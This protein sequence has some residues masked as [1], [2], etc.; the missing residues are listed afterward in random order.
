VLDD[1]NSLQ[2]ALLAPGLRAITLEAA[3]GRTA[4]VLDSFVGHF[5]RA[6]EYVLYTVIR[7][8]SVLVLAM[9]TGP[10]ALAVDLRFML[11]TFLLVDRGYGPFRAFRQRARLT[12][13]R[14]W[15]IVGADV[16]AAL[17]S[18]HRYGALE[19]DRCEGTRRAL[20]E[21]LLYDHLVKLDEAGETA[22]APAR[23]VVLSEPN[24]TW[25]LPAAAPVVATAIAQAAPLRESRDPDA[26]ACPRCGGDVTELTEPRMIRCT[27]CHGVWV[28]VNTSVRVARGDF[29]LHP[30]TSDAA[31]AASRVDLASKLRCPVCGNPMVRTYVAGAG[32]HLD[33]CAAHG[34]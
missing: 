15:N 2:W 3:R 12:R 28:D 22:N 6:P 33:A 1:T 10:F 26:P 32:V 30:A 34:T 29:P 24:P 31:A 27:A 13:G 9:F 16:G 14:V 25:P 19:R 17:D 18:L 11:A 8:V 4:R 23:P 7:E 5:Y 21:A 20:F